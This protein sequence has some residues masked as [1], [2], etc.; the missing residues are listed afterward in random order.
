M[1]FLPDGNLLVTQRGGTLVHRDMATGRTLVVTGTPDVVVAGQGGL[2]D[3]VLGPTY[4]TDRTVYLSWVEAGDGGT[5]GAVVGRATLDTAAAS[6]RDLR[7]IWRQDKTTGSGH[8]SHRLAFSPD[9]R[10]LFVTSGERQKFDPA[11]DL[12]TDLG[13]VLRLE[14]DGTT[15]PGKPFVGGAGRT[16]EIWSYG[17]RNGL[18]LAFDAEG[19]LWESEMGPQG[20]DEFNLI[21]EGANYG[22]PLVCNGS[23]Y[24]GADI[25][26]HAPGDGFEAPRV[27]WTPSIS[28]GSLM[29]Y[30]GSLFPQWRGDAFIGAL[31]GEALIRVHLDGT[32]ATKADQW[33]MGARIREVEQGPDGAIWL[34]EDG[35][36]GR[37][38][39][40]A[41]PA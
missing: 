12:D 39:R 9:G 14:P 33:P 25:P 30:S 29:I 5:S 1:T 32:S 6:L 24:G 28:P 40:L 37:L 4:G 16:A 11:Q 23:H 8:F 10:Y 20:G 36:G 35:P 17:H 41:P 21:R 13:K 15:A 22:W 7:V 34:L 18:G 3:I 38:L 2:G 31:S 27:W 19:N 26:D